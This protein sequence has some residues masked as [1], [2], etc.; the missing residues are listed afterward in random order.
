M[1]SNWRL[2]S[3]FGIPLYLDSS[4]FLVLAL[5]TLINAQEINATE[6]A[7]QPGIWGWIAGFIIAVLMFFSVLLHELGHSLAA[8]KQGIKVNAIT[9]FLFGGVASIEKESKSPID[10]FLVA[11]AGPLVSLGLFICFFGLSQYLPEGSLVRYVISDLALI[12]LVLTLFNLI[13]GLPLDGGQ[14][15]KAVVWQAT[16][17]PLK[18]LLWAA[19]SGRAIAWLAILIGLLLWLATGELGAA[20]LAFIGWFILRNAN[21][22]QRL[23]VLQKVLLDVK[24]NEVMTRDYRVVDGKLTLAEFVQ[25]YI[26]SDNRQSFPYYAAQEGRYCGMLKL[27]D[28]QRVERS[29]WE[30]I[31]L[32]TLAHPLTQIASL[33]EQTPLYRVI[34]SLETIPDPWITVLSPADAVSGVI[35]RGDIVRAIA[36]KLGVALPE[37]EIK[38]IKSERTYPPSLDLRAIASSLANTQDSSS[39]R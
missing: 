26:L 5:V 24:A 28:L 16:G 7:N 22:Y 36:H 1:Q 14:I 13:P 21:S 8:M 35:D 20:W 33:E 17:D 12:N 31:T 39:I 29:E 30:Q 4:W 37:T 2:G 27:S 38:R 15:L 9:L 10:A 34:E 23:A 3:L 25:Q 19:F 11:V 6:L 18:G 32:A